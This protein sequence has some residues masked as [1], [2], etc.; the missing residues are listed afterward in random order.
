M[1]IPAVF[2]FELTGRRVKVGHTEM[3]YRTLLALKILQCIGMPIQKQ[4]TILI[5]Y[6][7]ACHVICPVIF[8]PEDDCDRAPALTIFR[9]PN[10]L[11]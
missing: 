4:S 7:F 5:C 2:F 10:P 6:R 8:P 11:Q 3:F 1:A 9:H